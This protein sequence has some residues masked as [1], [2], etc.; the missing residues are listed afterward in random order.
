MTA[1]KNKRPS[2]NNSGCIGSINWTKMIGNYLA[3]CHFNCPTYLGPRI[4]K[5]KKI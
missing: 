5:K 3:G 1:M 2:A 4:R